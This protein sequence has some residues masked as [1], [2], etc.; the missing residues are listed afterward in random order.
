M[1]RSTPNDRLMD[2][3]RLFH[4][5]SLDERLQSCDGIA[6]AQLREL[7]K[8]TGRR[9]RTSPCGKSPQPVELLDY[10]HQLLEL[11]IYAP[12][13]NA[14]AGLNSDGNDLSSAVVLKNLAAD[15][16]LV[17]IDTKSD[18]GARVMAEPVALRSHDVT[19]PRQ[20]PS[21]QTGAS[22]DVRAIVPSL[23]R[24]LRSAA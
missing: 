2:I 22:D 8:L 20:P 18:R 11:R 5:D 14:A 12:R 13:A 9:W 4:G 3:H 15:D 21:I 16:I 23:F 19:D 24:T 1:P 10:V 6:L 17:L 7:S